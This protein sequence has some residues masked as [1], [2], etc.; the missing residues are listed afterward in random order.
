MII[1][2]N[3]KIDRYHLGGIILSYTQA[4]NAQVGLSVAVF[5]GRN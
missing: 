4:L 5:S 2:F 3:V 1:E